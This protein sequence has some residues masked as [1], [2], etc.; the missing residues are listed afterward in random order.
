MQS[1][2]L[3]LA[4]QLNIED[5]TSNQR[6]REALAKKGTFLYAKIKIILKICCLYNVG[7]DLYRF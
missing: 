3:S 4:I 5:T 7:N 6:S 1:L 2:K